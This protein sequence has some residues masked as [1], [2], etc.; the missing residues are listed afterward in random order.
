MGGDAKS[1]FSEER[2]WEMA[3]TRDAPSF[4]TDETVIMVKDEEDVRV[5]NA[6]APRASF[7]TLDP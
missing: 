3:P 1:I 2:A 6:V 7:T 4:D 5:F